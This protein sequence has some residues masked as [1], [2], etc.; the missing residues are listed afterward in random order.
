MQHVGNHHGPAAIVEDADA[1]AEH[2]R[3]AVARRVRDREARREIVGVVKI[4]LP[5]VAQ[6]VIDREART[7]LPVVLDVRAHLLFEQRQV[8]VALL[9]G[10]RVR[11]AR[12]VGVEVGEIERAAEVG[13]VVEAAP[14]PVG[15]LES[16]LHE[17][18]AVSP[19]Q[20]LVQVDVRLGAHEI[21]LRAAAGE[22]AGDDDAAIGREAGGRLALVAEQHLKL[23]HQRRPEDRLLR[24][25][26]LL[27]VMLERRRRAGQRRAA[28]AAVLVALVLVVRTNRERVLVA[29][30]VRDAAGDARFAARVRQLAVDRSVESDRV[31]EGLAGVVLVVGRQHER[32]LAVV[33]DRP[34]EELLRRFAAAPAVS[35]SRTRCARSSGRRGRAC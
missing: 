9:L 26:D 17:M 18:L 23:V 30:L 14:A 16:G 10:E 25:G 8:A 3:L 33:A 28:G 13:P 20:A 1:G 2:V 22:R 6:A 11:L 19:R 34:A 32:R 29:D 21:D 15:Q 27:L 4:V 24:V 12:L 7:H 5:V 31:D 35:R